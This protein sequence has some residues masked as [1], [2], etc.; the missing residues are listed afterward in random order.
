[1]KQVLLFSLTA[2][3]NPTLLGVTTVMLLAENPKKLML[4]YLLGAL[5]TSVTLGLLIVFSLQDSDAVSTTK[6]TLNP[7][8]DLA[9]GTILLVIAYVLGTARHERLKERRQRR[10]GAAREKPPPR[11]RR[12]LDRGSPRIAF[13]VGAALTLPGVSYLAALDG[14]TKLPYDTAPKVLVIVMVNLVMLAPIEV[15]LLSFAIAPEWTT[16]ALDRVKAW[17]ARNGRR[18]AVIGTAT[19]GSLLVVKGLITLLT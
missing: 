11:W 5:L 15:P 10:K 8:A 6:H 2:M 4:G 18:A 7:V 13:V 16:V 19:V 1:M 12:A 17:F 14:I 3:A 9:L